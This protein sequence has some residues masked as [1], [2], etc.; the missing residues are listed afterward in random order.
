MAEHNIVGKIGENFACEYIIKK[1]YKI[2]YRNYKEKWDEID[3]IAKNRDGTVVFFEVK[4]IKNYKDSDDHIV[5]EDNMTE[6]K[7]AK[8]SRACQ[9]FAAKH[10]ELVIEDKGWQID[11]LALTIKDDNCIIKHYEN[12]A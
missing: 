9:M 2:L 3:I 4:T 6:S 12:I 10:S 1:G 7:L 5:P 8:I 11:L